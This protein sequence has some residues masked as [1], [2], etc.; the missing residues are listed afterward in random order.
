MCLVQ[1]IV[2]DPA[3]RIIFCLVASLAVLSDA[4]IC[5]ASNV[6]MQ[7]SLVLQTVSSSDVTGVLVMTIP[8]KVF[9]DLHQLRVNSIFSFANSELSREEQI[10]ITASGMLLEVQSSIEV[11]SS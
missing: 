1:Q 9:P 3:V 11:V 6:I 10:K 2:N 8:F 7:M 5:R 4:A